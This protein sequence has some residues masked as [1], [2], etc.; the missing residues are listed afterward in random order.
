[1]RQK[2]KT[3]DELAQERLPESI[4][5]A[6]KNIEISVVIQKTTWFHILI[7]RTR[8]E[9]NIAVPWGAAAT[10]VI[11]LTKLGKHFKFWS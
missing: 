5:T 1:M 8:C 9:L 6:I 2:R 3:I 11:A 7:D 10:F 4:N